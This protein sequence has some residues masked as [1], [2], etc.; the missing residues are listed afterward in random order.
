M[1][2]VIYPA[3]KERNYTGKIWELSCVA[4]LNYENTLEYDRK[5]YQSENANSNNTYMYV[6]HGKVA[7]RYRTQSV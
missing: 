5:R 1:T 4:S 3:N 7:G 6:I 2:K